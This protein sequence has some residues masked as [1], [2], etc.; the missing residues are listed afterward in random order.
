M[1]MKLK[2]P[3]LTGKL[4]ED[5][6]SSIY[7]G[8]EFRG[9]FINYMVIIESR[10]EQ[11]IVNFFGNGN[12]SFEKIRDDGNIH[13]IEGILR[14]CWFV[15]KH[16][17]FSQKI[18]VYTNIIKM[19]KHG[20]YENFIKQYFVLLN[21]LVQLRNFVAHN[22]A[23]PGTKEI[24]AFQ[25]LTAN[26]KGVQV[27]ATNKDGSQ[28]ENAKTV[29]Y[30]EWH[31]EVVSIKIDLPLRKEINKQAVIM[32][33]FLDNILEYLITPMNKHTKEMIDKFII[34]IKNPLLK[35]GGVY[36]LFKENKD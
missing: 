13:P 6:E 15:D 21:R 4:T 30:K 3:T 14:Y 29:T 5:E 1:L 16:C 27:K 35:K 2:T 23:I 17:T 12:A 32:A 36:T 26:Y 18:N 9:Y 25:K 28:K 34:D 24:I 7:S 8:A 19:K 11:G 33:N 31:G 20:H 22:S 10:I